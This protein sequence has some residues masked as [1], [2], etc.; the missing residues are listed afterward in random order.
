MANSA[1][2]PNPNQQPV[3]RGPSQR[4]S[5]QR[6]AAAIADYV[7]AALTVTAWLVL[8]AAGLGAAY[9]AIKAVIWA[10]KLAQQALG[11]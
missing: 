2:N 4:P 6:I 1:P 5:P 10:V 7:R 3:G 9:V 8:G 11:I